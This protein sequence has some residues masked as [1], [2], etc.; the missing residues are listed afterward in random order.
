MSLKKYS[1]L[2][3]YCLK[4]IHNFL[5]VSIATQKP[6]SK[7]FLSRSLVIERSPL[8]EEIRKMFKKAV[9]ETPPPTKGRPSCATDTKGILYFFEVHIIPN[10]FFHW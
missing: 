9:E 3:T 4:Y 2:T 1:C 8:S 5:F 7:D 6:V 10:L